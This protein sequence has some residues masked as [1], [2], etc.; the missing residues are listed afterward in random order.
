MKEEKRE[1][2]RQRA[3]RAG[4]RIDELPTGGYRIHGRNGFID[5]R[6]SDL[7]DVHLEDLAP[8]RWA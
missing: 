5:F 8:R 6:V 3:A 7:A 1:V 2:V 4:I